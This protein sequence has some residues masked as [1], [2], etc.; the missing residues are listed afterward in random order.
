MKSIRPE[1]IGMVINYKANNGVKFQ[2]EINAN[3]IEFYSTI[4][5]DVFE[6]RPVTKAVIAEE[7]VEEV[8]EIVEEKPKSKKKNAPTK[9]ND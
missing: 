2:L 5:L 6:S 1:C 8:I 3:D 7:I 4:G 9:T